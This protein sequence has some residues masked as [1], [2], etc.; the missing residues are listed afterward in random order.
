VTTEAQILDLMRDIQAELGM[1]IMYITHDLGVIA[2]MA[3]NVVV[4]YLGKIV[5]Q[6][7]VDALFYEPMH[8]YTR[9]LLKSIPRV[10][11]KA[12]ERLEAIKGMV[13]DPYAMPGGCTFH[14]RCPDAIPGVCDRQIPELV[15]INPQHAVMCHLYSR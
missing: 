8:P 14:P 10:D 11:R 9:A 4:M 7:S 2:E 5:E 15:S 1:S 6:A 12:V 13:P 3:E